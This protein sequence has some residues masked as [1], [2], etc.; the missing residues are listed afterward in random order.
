MRWHSIPCIVVVLTLVCA[1]VWTLPAIAA[2]NGGA[3]KIALQLRLQPGKT[4]KMRINVEQQV[5]PPTRE[6]RTQTVAMNLAYEVQQVEGNGDAAVKLTFNSVELKAAELPGKEFTLPNLLAVDPILDKKY[7]ALAGKSCT[8]NVNPAGGISGIAG[9]DAVPGDMRLQSLLE[10]ILAVYPSRPVAIG[11]A[12]EQSKFAPALLLITYI[13]APDLTMILKNT[14]MLKSRKQGVAAL[15]VKSSIEANPA[16][17]PIGGM[18]GYSGMREG[19]NGMMTSE[20]N[21][22]STLI[23]YS[24]LGDQGGIVEFDEETGWPLRGKLVVRYTTDIQSRRAPAGAAIAQPASRPQWF[25]CQRTL[26]F[27]SE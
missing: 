19:P 22:Y 23:S 3:E 11:D 21:T 17:K 20:M 27:S 24:F 18:G 10:Q 5:Y 13:P 7:A 4:Y 16:D 1:G 9:D 14:W 6:G 15:E 25:S 12:W 8:F 2:E 26:T